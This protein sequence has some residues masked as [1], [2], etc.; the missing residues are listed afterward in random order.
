ML[1]ECTQRRWGVCWV[2]AHSRVLC[3]CPVF[4]GGC[5]SSL[6]AGVVGHGG[7]DGTCRQGHGYAAMKRHVAVVCRGRGGP[8]RKRVQCQVV[9]CWDAAVCVS[10]FCGGLCFLLG[11]G[12][13]G[14]RWPGRYVPP[15]SRVCRNETARRSSVS[16]PRRSSEK[17]GPMP[18][19]D[20]LGCC[21]W[22]GL[23]AQR[24]ARS[25]QRSGD[26]TP[27]I[28]FLLRPGG[29]TATREGGKCSQSQ[30]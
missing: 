27:A 15:R 5:A 12:C 18:G 14:S 13:G 2:A 17:E 24:R 11:C 22:C 19:G 28:F 8:P 7:R 21:W 16:R 30:R 3:V 6:V 20:M 10:C 1:R 25:K 29:V 23:A 4:V 9:T 26:V